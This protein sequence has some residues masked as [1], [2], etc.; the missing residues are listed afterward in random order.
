[1]ADAILCLHFAFVAFVAGGLAAITAGGRARA[2]WALNRGVRAAHLAAT[3]FIA[4]QA[5][6]GRDGPLTS[7]KSRLRVAAGPTAGSSAAA[8]LDGH[9]LARG[10]PDGRLLELPNAKVPPTHF[11][12]PRA[13]FHAV[14]LEPNETGGMR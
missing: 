6:R 12:R 2:R 7:V 1:M 10:E 4:V 3:P 14:H 9:W 8:P 13:R 5:W 11:E